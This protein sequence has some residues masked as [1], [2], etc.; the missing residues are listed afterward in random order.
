MST[1]RGPLCRYA[2]MEDVKRHEATVKTTVSV[3]QCLY[4]SS[5]ISLS[6]PSQD[7]SHT[8]VVSLSD[9]LGVCLRI[10]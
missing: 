3:I 9:S 5:I 4:R 7:A 1:Q 8:T 10:S 6:I 2:R